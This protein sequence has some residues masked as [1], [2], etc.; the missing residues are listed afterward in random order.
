VLV[1]DILNNVVWVFDRKDG[2][3]LEKVGYMGRNGGGFHWLH[4]LATDAK[5][6]F[7]TGEVDTGRRVQRFLAQ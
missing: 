5:G 7:Y 3:L 6:N 4:M 1:P 2:K